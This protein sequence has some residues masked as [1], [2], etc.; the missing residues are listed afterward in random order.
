MKTALL[1]NGSKKFWGDG[2]RLNHTLQGVAKQWLESHSYFVRETIIDRGYDENEE[3]EKWLDSNLVIWQFPSWWM[4]EP[5]IV[6]EYID[7]VFSAGFGRF[8]KSD[9]R[10]RDNPDVN[11]G[12]GGLLQGK[13]AMISMTWNAPLRAFEDKNEFFEGQGIEMVVFHLRKAHEWN[14]ITMLPTFMCND[15]IKNPQVERYIADYK[16]HLEKTLEIQTSNKFQ[17]E[18]KN[19]E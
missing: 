3:V 13:K 5:Y 17:T 19:D 6:K 2:T 8:S 16:A 15:V 18:G 9:G 7:K 11:Y 10:H 1:I 4:G 14:G 12:T